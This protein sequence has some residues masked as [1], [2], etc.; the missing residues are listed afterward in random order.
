M[1]KHKDTRKR[2]YSSIA[3]IVILFGMLAVTTWAL[4]ASFVTVEENMF[5]MGT[6]EI[7]LNGGQTI[8][9]GTDLNI[10]PGHTVKKE[11]TIENKGTADVYYRLY[12]ENVTGSL[13]EVLRFEIYD[14]EKQLFEGT[15]AELNK[16]TPCIG[17]EE[18]K[19]GETK[20]LTAL[21]KMEESAGNAYQTGGISFDVTADAVQAKN[22]PEKAFE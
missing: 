21:V 9:D 22:N 15:A 2:A 6:V 8:F 12:L 1:G 14:G 20:M 19:V 11:F 13:Q 16:E 18:L 5:Q 3:A 10:E 17:E 7:E 4:I